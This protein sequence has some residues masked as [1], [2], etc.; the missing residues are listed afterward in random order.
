MLDLRDVPKQARGTVRWT[1]PSAV[2][3][4]PSRMELD[5]AG[6]AARVPTSQIR[7][8]ELPMIVFAVISDSARLFAETKMPGNEGHRESSQTVINE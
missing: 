8:A 6:A 2:A 3:A 7:F 1:V 4:L 5:G